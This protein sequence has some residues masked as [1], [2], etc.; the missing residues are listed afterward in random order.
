[1]QVNLYAG[2]GKITPRKANELYLQDNFD[3]ALEYYKYLVKADENNIVYNLRLG[4]C[5]LNT[6]INKSLAIPYFKTV[7]DLDALDQHVNYA[8]A[9]YL[10]GKAYHYDNQFDLA[11]E[12]LEIFLKQEN[13]TEEDA[14]WAR[15]KI[16]FCYNAKELIKYPVDVT[17]EN[18]GKEINSP[19][20][21]YYPHVPADESFLIFNS[22]RDEFADKLYNGSFASNVYISE[23]SQG[24]FKKARLIGGKINTKYYNEAIIGM[25]AN[26]HDG[27]FYID[28]ED[29]LI[30]LYLGEI[31]DKEVM[32]I[33]NL[34]PK[35]NSND[36]EIAA[37]IT[38]D[39][40]TMYIASKRKGGFGGSDI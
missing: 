5:Y 35:Y 29:D 23:V 33:E 25:S 19:Y 2:E 16:Q 17:F 30:D 31:R 22:K 34:N 26:G 10:L 3:E 39:G 24:N 1:M 18:L 11:I 40:N 4:V 6:Y 21:D 9:Y 36:L 28:N 37:S 14:E 20:A 8:I 38:A 12:T 15:Q 7:I 32:N 13:I 27:I